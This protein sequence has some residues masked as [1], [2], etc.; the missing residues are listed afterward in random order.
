MYKYAIIGLGGLGKLHLGNLLRLEQERGDFALQAIC[1]KRP[2]QE[3]NVKLNLG[4]VDLGSIDFSKYRYYAD[5]KEMLAQED[6]DFVISVLPTFMHEEVAVYALEHGVHIFSEKPMALTL[7]A[8]D[9]MLDAAEKSGK[10]LM[11]GQCLRFDP[12]YRKVRDYI[13]TGELGHCYRAE[14]TRYSPIPGWSKGGW[15]V[16]V[17]LSGGC[18]F[19]MHVHDVDLINWMFGH[20]KSLRSAVT[21][22]KLGLE[23]IFTQYFY[24]GLL[25]SSAAD[26]SMPGTFPFEA[27]SLF[28]F[29][30]ATVVV[31]DDRVTVY[32]DEET[33][34]AELD[35]EDHFLDEMRAFLRMVIDG[36][37]CPDADP[38]TVRESVKLARWEIDAADRI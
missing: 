16:D 34:E 4:T 10:R 30:K 11:I 23:S 28:N 15:I 6:L 19:D 21:E 27:R 35:G 29:E 17:K 20:P 7:D 31:K 26:W 33:F 14:F 22:V 32:Q 3:S 9:R 37:D 18:A 38:A 8:C 12:A 5:Y 1:D 36:V 13:R 25:V 2:P 24:D